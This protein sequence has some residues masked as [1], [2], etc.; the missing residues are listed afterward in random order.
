M[1]VAHRLRR[2]PLRRALATAARPPVAAREERRVEQV[3]V[4]GGELVELPLPERRDHVQLDVPPV[5]VVGAG[6]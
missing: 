3:D 2:E 5:R 1:D 6:T 4:L